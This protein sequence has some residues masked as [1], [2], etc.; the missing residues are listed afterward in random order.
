MLANSSLVKKMDIFF[1]LKGYTNIGNHH[2]GMATW[3]HITAGI[4]N[5]IQIAFV[6]EPILSLRLHD[7]HAYRLKN[8]ETGHVRRQVERPTAT[9]LVSK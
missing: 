5:F 7:N 6:L 8:S 2:P 4:H 1:L 9:D 3:Q